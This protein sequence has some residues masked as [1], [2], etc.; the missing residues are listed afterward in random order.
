MARNRIILRPAGKQFE[1]FALHMGTLTLLSDGHEL[2]VNTLDGHIALVNWDM[3]HFCD[4]CTLG[5]E[6]LALM[7]ILLNDWPSYVPNERL[8]QIMLK[9]SIERVAD[10][11][12]NSPDQVI[13]PLQRMV[14]SCR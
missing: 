14:A 2:V 11:L 10:L 5:Q 13:G 3:R 12:D 9:A 7:L 1:S 8:L 6:E 4:D